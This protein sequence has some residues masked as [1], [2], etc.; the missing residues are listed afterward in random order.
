M[1]ITNF[2]DIEFVKYF[3]NYKNC[4]I[5]ENYL[6]TEICKYNEYKETEIKFGRKPLNFFQFELL[7]I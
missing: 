2:P 5:N 1:P 6:T 7:N 4:E 3:S